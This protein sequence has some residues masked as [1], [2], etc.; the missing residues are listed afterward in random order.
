[1]DMYKKVCADVLIC[2]SLLETFKNI[3]LIVKSY[4]ALIILIIDKKLVPRYAKGDLYIQ[5]ALH[6]RTF[7]YTFIS[8]VEAL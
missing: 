2:T 8:F 6:T 3:L 7:I 4:N 5:G 1:M